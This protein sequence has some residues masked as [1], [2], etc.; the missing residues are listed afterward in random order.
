MN[1][2]TDIYK[3]NNWLPPLS[4]AVW[5]S[6]LGVAVQLAKRPSTLAVKLQDMCVEF[7]GINGWEL[8]VSPYHNPCPSLLTT[9]WVGG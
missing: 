9:V 7:P 5:I 3:N 2:F 6:L 1:L 4:V 8:I